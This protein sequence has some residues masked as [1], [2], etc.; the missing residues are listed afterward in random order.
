MKILIAED[1]LVTRE[2]LK[3]IL[4]HMSDEIVEAGDGLEAL[5]MIEKEDPDFLFTDLQMPELGGYELVEAVR[6]SKKHNQLPVVCMS[7][8]K[9]KDEVTRLVALGVQDYIL[10]PIRPAEVHDRFRKVIAQHSGWR[11]RQGAEGARILLLVDV[12]PNFR[13]F[14]RTFLSPPFTVLEAISGA[15][16]LRVYKDAD[17]KPTVVLA[18]RGLPLVNEVQLKNLITRMAAEASGLAPSFWL[19]ADEQPPR[20]IMQHFVG[21]VRR[22]FVPDAFTAELRRTLLHGHSPVDKLRLHFAEDA[23][24][25]SLTATR[26]TLGVMSGQEVKVVDAPEN[27]VI[28]DGVAG[29][30]SLSAADVSV[31]VLIAC[32]A[33][34]AVGLAGKVLR[35]E[36]T[37][38]SGGADVFGELSNTIGGRARAGLIEA[39]FDLTISLPDIVTSYTTDPTEQW[40]LADWFETSEGSRFFVGMRCEELANAGLAPSALQSAAALLSSDSVDDALF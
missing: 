11:R 17:V 7:S 24:R 22:S 3:R 33:A 13:E 5:E 29:R 26:Q 32:A 34:D 36:V 25:W 15:H 4:S 14:A 19:C 28:T 23:R 20:D 40:D 38:D 37:L 9:D 16:A 18:A 1:D 8:V 2:L 10:K 21:L 30:I 35:R 12:D 31:V 6:N 27:P 39:G